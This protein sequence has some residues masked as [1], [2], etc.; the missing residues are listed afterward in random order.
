MRI[1][2]AGAADLLLVEFDV[3]LYRIGIARHTSPI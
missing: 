1:D 2:Q 3:A